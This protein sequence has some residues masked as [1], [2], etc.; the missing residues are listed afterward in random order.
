MPQEVRHGGVRGSEMVAQ[1]AG[2]Q[3]FFGR[4]FHNL[5]TFEPSEARLK[6][7]AKGMLE[8]AADQK[9]ARLRAAFEKRHG[10]LLQAWVPKDTTWRSPSPGT[11]A[12][13]SFTPPKARSCRCS[14]G[15]S[16]NARPRTTRVCAS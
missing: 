7:L 6:E 9:P 11:V 4:M 3:G 5:P 15:S 8:R 2:A 12:C 14:S 1:A 10:K 13:G 16:I